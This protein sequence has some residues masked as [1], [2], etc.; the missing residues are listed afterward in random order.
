MIFGNIVNKIYFVEM[1]ATMLCTMLL[2]IFFNNVIA[3]VISILK[4][5]LWCELGGKQSVVL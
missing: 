2:F 1:T 5:K 4:K 3:I